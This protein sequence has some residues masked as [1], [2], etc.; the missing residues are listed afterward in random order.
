MAYILE[1]VAMQMNF[2]HW[3]VRF[4]VFEE[5]M[6]RL[7]PPVTFDAVQVGSRAHRLRNYWTNLVEGGRANAVFNN[8][9]LP[10]QGPLTE[11]LGPRRHTT[12]VGAT[13]N[14]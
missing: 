4:P 6:S 11:I 7:G 14:L 8:I 10:V 13:E 5:L 12:E 9:M 1:N 3:H 2:R